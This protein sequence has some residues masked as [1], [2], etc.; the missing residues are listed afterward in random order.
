[1]AAD[2][3]TIGAALERARIAYAALDEADALR[4]KMG[5]LIDIIKVRLQQD[6]RGLR[7]GLPHR[8]KYLNKLKTSS[9]QRPLREAAFVAIDALLELGWQPMTNTERTQKKR[10]KPEAVQEREA[11]LKKTAVAKA[12][13]AE[14]MQREQ[15]DRLCARRRAE[16]R[17]GL[18]LHMEALG[19][20]E[21]LR[22]IIRTVR[23]EM[24]AQQREEDEYEREMARIKAAGIQLKSA[25]PNG[26]VGKPSLPRFPYPLGYC[27]S[28]GCDQDANAAHGGRLCDECFRDIM[29]TTY[30]LC[31]VCTD[32]G[33]ACML[34][35]QPCETC[36]NTQ[37]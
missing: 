4:P 1:M 23:A 12:V 36:I 24:W 28:C 22:T 37:A 17:V 32:A 5:A 14:Q 21:L 30:G 33:F 11:K 34:R 9:P 29:H 20:G 18:Q 25:P 13:A 31:S 7:P 8:G 35:P 27:W 6:D 3:E 15:R 19:S 16:A 10:G 26:F 2:D